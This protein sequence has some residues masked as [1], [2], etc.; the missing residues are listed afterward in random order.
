MEATHQRREEVARDKADAMK[1]NETDETKDDDN[2]KVMRMKGED[3]DTSVTQQTN[4]STIVFH[5]P[6]FTPPSS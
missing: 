5:H 3:D 1:V 4:T 6:S 2:G